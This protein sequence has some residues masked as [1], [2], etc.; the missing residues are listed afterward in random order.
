VKGRKQLQD[1]LKY[2]GLSESDIIAIRFVHGNASAEP[3]NTKLLVI[4]Q[5]IPV[6]ETYWLENGFHDDISPSRDVVSVEVWTN[7]YI[8]YTREYDT[9]H[10]LQ[11]VRRNPPVE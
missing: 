7:D 11:S 9:S 2:L 4:E 1:E 10:T 3:M 8:I 5:A 6:L